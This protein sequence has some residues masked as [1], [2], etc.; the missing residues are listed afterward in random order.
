MLT[1]TMNAAGAAR[2]SLLLSL[3]VFAAAVIAPLHCEAAEKEQPCLDCHKKLIAKR[4]VHPAI[5]QYV[6]MEQGCPSCH[7][8]PHGKKKAVKS[9]TEP[10]PGLCFQCHE[11][12]RFTK[13]NVHPPVAA[14]DCTVCHDPHAADGNTLLVQPLPYLCQSCHEDQKDGK[15]ILRG[16]GLG[17]QHPI[18]GKKDPSRIRRELTCT[19]CHSPHSSNAPSLFPETVTSPQEL[20]QQCHRR[21]MV[22]P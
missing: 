16:S 7:T 18:Q 21:I 2:C 13:Q 1:G 9:L 12:E 15:H 19:S 6:R 5:S 20:C 17:D 4:T 14:G 11:K 3:L 22:R 10:V 8:S